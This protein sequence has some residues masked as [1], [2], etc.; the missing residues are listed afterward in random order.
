[1][2]SRLPAW[3]YTLLGNNISS[4]SPDVTSSC[5][6]IHLFLTFAAFIM[7]VDKTGADTIVRSSFGAWRRLPLRKA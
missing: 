5:L 2:P 6:M 1:M 4:G 3:L 7:T